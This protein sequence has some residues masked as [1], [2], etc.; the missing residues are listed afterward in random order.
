MQAE[1]MISIYLVLWCDLL[2]IKMEMFQS[3]LDSS[4]PMQWHPWLWLLSLNYVAFCMINRLT[5]VF[6]T[7]SFETT[8]CVSSWCL[9]S[10]LASELSHLKCFFWGVTP[11]LPWSQLNRTSLL[12]L[13][14]WRGNICCHLAAIYHRVSN[15]PMFP[16]GTLEPS[17]IIALDAFCDLQKTSI[18]GWSVK[19]NKDFPMTL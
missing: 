13:L 5:E 1:S 14:C 15:S 9:I 16:P 11:V 12:L 3:L 7:A 10:L 19:Q 4:N 2:Y 18:K 17:D 6:V 8:S